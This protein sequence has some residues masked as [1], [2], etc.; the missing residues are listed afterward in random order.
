MVKRTDAGAVA[1]SSM[2]R[3][4]RTWQEMGKIHQAIDTYLRLVQEHPTSKEAEDA[5]QALLEIATAYE[6]DGC[7]HLA[8]DIFDRLGAVAE[9]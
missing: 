1:R 6:A 4:G 9:S 5:R 3:M 2:L 8:I 7:Y